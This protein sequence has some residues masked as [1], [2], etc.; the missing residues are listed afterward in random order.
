LNGVWTTLVAVLGTLAG[1]GLTAAVQ[2]RLARAN[3]RE[4]R[5]AD[6]LAAVTQLA[7]ALADHRRAM[8]VVEDS[9][10]SGAPEQTVDEAQTK[11]HDTRAAIEIPLHTVAI[12]VPA[13]AQSAEEAT[14][15]TFAM[16]NAEDHDALTTLRQ[17]AKDTH[18]RFVAAA[19]VVFADSGDFVA[20]S[21]S[22]RN[23]AAQ[24]EPAV[25]S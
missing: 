21:R 13:L 14:R 15:A 5:R 6:A 9:R 1:G 16:R 24:A 22:T 2:G 19:R 25:T 18:S 11:R 10:L 20:T 12:L 7:A 17:E 3:R 4:A 8:W 23:K